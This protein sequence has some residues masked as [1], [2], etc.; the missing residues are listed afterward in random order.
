MSST[1]A[2]SAEYKRVIPARFVTQRD[3][4]PMHCVTCGADLAMG[5]SF[6]ATPGTGWHSYCAD[7]AESFPHQVR[8][9]VTKLTAMGVKIP[10]AMTALV[11]DFLTNET[12]ARAI[13]AKAALMALRSETGKA[14]AAASA[15]D[16]SA[17]PAGK[18]AVP[19]GDT[20]LKVQIDNVATGKWANWIFVSD[21]AEYGQRKRYGSQ[22]PGAT[23][24][25]DII[26][27]LRL[28]AADPRAASA[29]YGRLT[30]KCGVCGRPLEDAE[31]V[32][33]GIGPICNGK[34]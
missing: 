26:D 13:V 27:Q 30:S 19:G 25:G 16:L 20:R 22:K 6:A 4:S 34:F 8:G 3:G 2:L 18:Y 7:C 23:Y 21:G 9:L 15:L 17:L 32:A 10:D 1:T 11:I 12:P 28:I 31:S 33:R 5:R 29:A 24:K 14:A